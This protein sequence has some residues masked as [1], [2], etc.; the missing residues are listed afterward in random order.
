MKIDA[1]QNILYEAFKIDQVIRKAFEDADK[2]KPFCVLNMKN[3]RETIKNESFTPYY[4]TINVILY[5][6]IISTNKLIKHLIAI[7][8]LEII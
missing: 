7:L 4:T 8:V 5:I 1:N 3:S 2:V 6:I